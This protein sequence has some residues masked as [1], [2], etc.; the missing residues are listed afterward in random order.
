MA[1]YKDRRNVVCISDV[2]PF[3][4]SLQFFIRLTVTVDI[5]QTDT[6]ILLS[7]SCVF[8]QLCPLPYIIY[9]IPTYDYNRIFRLCVMR[10]N[11]KNIS[12]IIF[13][14]LGL[15]EYFSFCYYFILFRDETIQ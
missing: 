11:N 15:T 12:H 13:E 2:F 3:F 7:V 9:Y 5:T 10:H 8:V 4:F 14:P 6:G 1:T